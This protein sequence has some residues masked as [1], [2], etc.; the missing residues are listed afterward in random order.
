M[1]TIRVLFVSSGNAFQGISP[2]V[3]AQGES[4]RK[5][6]IGIE[7]FPIQGHGLAGYLKNVPVLHKFLKQNKFDLVHAH[8]S[9]SGMVAGLAGARPLVESL[10]G[11]D[12][13]LKGFNFFM[14]HVTNKLFWSACI[15]KSKDML[16]QI[17]I[18]ASILPNGVDIEHFKPMDQDECRERLKLPKSKKI[19]LFLADPKRVEKNFPLAE[20]AFKLMK[21]DHIQLLQ[22]HDISHELVPIYLNAADVVLLTS[23]W[24]GSPNIIKEAMACNCSIVSTDV[25]DVRW[26]LDGLIG[27]QVTN[28][29]PV[30]VAGAISFVLANGEGGIKTCG[31]DRL[32]QLKLDSGSIAVQLQ[33]LYISVIKAKNTY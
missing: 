33:Q 28:S 26:L 3:K 5:L 1:K 10:M 18:K 32:I 27:C 16:K 17:D 6:G 13:H 20:E 29:N 2:I 9:L 15:V 11:S 4:L 23:L 7:Y 8:Y 30:D 24:E 22:V 21:N 12:C 19:V 25:G 31:R 14:M